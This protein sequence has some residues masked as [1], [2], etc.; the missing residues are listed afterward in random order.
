MRAG[1][2]SVLFIANC[3]EAGCHLESPVEER[4]ALR[5][6]GKGWIERKR[7]E[8]VN[9]APVPSPS[10]IRETAVMWLERVQLSSNPPRCISYRQDMRTREE[11]YRKVPPDR[12]G[13][14]PQTHLGPAEWINLENMHEALRSFQNS[15]E[16]VSEVCVWTLTGRKEGC[17]CV[18]VYTHGV[19]G[20]TAVHPGCVG[21][22]SRPPASQVHQAGLTKHVE[23]TP[24]EK[25]WGTRGS[26]SPLFPTL[27]NHQRRPFRGSQWHEGSRRVPHWD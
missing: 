27:I 10:P 5:Q 11:S 25:H 9:G 7:M 22:Q 20:E 14:Q 24:E 2:T 6:G 26:P 8:T 18:C 17:V 12:T 4:R 3:H 1:S 15:K 21:R 19:G 23:I 16:T 13:R